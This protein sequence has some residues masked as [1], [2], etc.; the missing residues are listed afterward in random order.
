MKEKLFRTNKKDKSYQNKSESNCYNI[1]E[2]KYISHK[3]ENK[4]EKININNQNQP[5]ITKITLDKNYQEIEFI[6]KKP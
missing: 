2:K 1:L 4:P 3:S 5:A 6:Q